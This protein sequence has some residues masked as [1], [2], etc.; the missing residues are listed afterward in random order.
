[1]SASAL[2]KSNG[3]YQYDF[4]T[5]A[6]Q[7]FGIN[8]QKEIASGIW[9]MY[10]GDINGDGVINSNDK[11]DNWNT[12]AGMSGYMTSD[13][14]LDGEADNIDKDEYWV[15]NMEESCQIPE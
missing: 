11:S 15:E 13:L 9:G 3:V 2:Q 4:T 5:G 10:S 8:A 14:N 1:M 7:A 12:E 6:G